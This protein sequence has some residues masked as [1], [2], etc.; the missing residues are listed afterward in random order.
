V[1]STDIV[2][3][4]GGP[5]GL[6]AGIAARQKGFAVT[7]V[8]AAKPPIDKACGEGLMPEG[9]DA[10]TSLGVHIGE[11]ESA[12]FRGIRFIQEGAEARA[13]FPRGS[14]L[15]VR[16]TTLHRL[17]LKRAEEAGVKLLWNTPVRHLD[18]ACARWIIGADGINSYIRK[19]AGVRENRI[20]VRRFGFRRH[21]QAAP[22]SDTVDVYW[23][24]TCQIY[25]TPVTANEVGVAMLSRH[26]RLRLEEA[27]REFPDVERRL[28]GLSPVSSERGAVTQCRRL[29]T[30][31]RGNVALIGDA[32]GSVDAITGEG[33]ALSFKQ[34]VALADALAANDLAQ[35]AV[36]HA[37]IVRPAWRMA[38]VLLLMDQHAWLRRR[39]IRALAAESGLFAKLLA[40]HT[41]AISPLDFGV[42]GWCT[43]GW[44]FLIA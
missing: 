3:I 10:L 14:G 4:G 9:V 30:V 23:G 27:V 33:L 39:M 22:W 34:A 13:E 7:I 11:T 15:G 28:S 31:Y 1:G 2:I 43:L 19:W 40:M 17:L 5:A 24:R 16:R 32:S 37:G 25:V 29:R 36:A 18:T 20:G 35:Y 8:D 12:R 26:K 44:E 42:A 21:F 38:N 6:A 41:G